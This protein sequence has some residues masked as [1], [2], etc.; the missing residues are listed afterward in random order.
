MQFQILNFR[1]A[2]YLSIMCDCSAEFFDTDEAIVHVIGEHCSEETSEN[3]A[4]VK[5]ATLLSPNPVNFIE[6][7]H[8]CQEILK[9]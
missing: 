3:E 2:G 8:Q 1:D 4:W 6:G 7:G 5:V 9:G